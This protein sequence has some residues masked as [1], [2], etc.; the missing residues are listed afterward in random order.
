[1]PW[2]GRRSYAICAVIMGAQMKVKRHGAQI[3]AVCSRQRE[4]DGSVGEFSTAG[5]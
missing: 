3:S 5:S 2:P 1:M 4:K